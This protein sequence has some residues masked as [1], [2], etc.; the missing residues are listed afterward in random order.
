M[1]LVEELQIDRDFVRI[2]GFLLLGVMAKPE[3]ANQRATKPGRID[4]MGFVGC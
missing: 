1:F 2:G 3:E 4:L